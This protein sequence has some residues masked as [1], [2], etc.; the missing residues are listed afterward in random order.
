MTKPVRTAIC[1]GRQAPRPVSAGRHRHR[2]PGHRDRLGR[3]H[4]GRPADYR[5]ALVTPEAKVGEAVLT[6]RLVDTRSGQPVTDAVI[7][8]KRIDSAPTAW[9]R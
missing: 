3:I 6:V 9:T 1:P 2:H 4:P 8:A 5:F 7:F